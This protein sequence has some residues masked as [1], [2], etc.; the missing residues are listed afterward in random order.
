MSVTPI[1]APSQR[2]SMP[3]F[4]KIVTMPVSWQIGRLPSAH[5]RLFVRICAMASFAAGLSS[6]SYARPSASM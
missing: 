4:T 3:T 5:M 2:T 1:V 6:S